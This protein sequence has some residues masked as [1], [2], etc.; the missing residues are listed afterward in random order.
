MMDA[1]LSIMSNSAPPGN[2]GFETESINKTPLPLSEYYTSTSG[3]SQFTPS[4][5]V[6][7]APGTTF[8][9]ESTGPTPT[10]GPGN[11]DYNKDDDNDG[12]NDG[13][14]NE[15]AGEKGGAITPRMSVWA[16]LVIGGMLLFTLVN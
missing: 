6:T 15:G 8:L 11:E 10:G 12:D 5:T 14:E 2:L 7:P 16:T 1:Y 13:G 3:T 4:V 9:S